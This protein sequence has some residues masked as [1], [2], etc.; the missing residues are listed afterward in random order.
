MNLSTDLDL[1]TSDYL[2]KLLVITFRCLLTSKRR[3]MAFRCPY[4]PCLSWV[5]GPLY[6][7][8]QKKSR[9]YVTFKDFKDKEMEV[10]AKA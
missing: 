4:S 7:L 8:S 6:L 2:G 9:A 5:G 10:I 1:L 3:H